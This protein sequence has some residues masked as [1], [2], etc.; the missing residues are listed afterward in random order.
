[1]DY[2]LLKL[3]ADF[4]QSA[5][6]PVVTLLLHLYMGYFPPLVIGAVL[7][8]L[9]VLTSPLARLHLL[10]LFTS[11]PPAKDLKRPWRAKGIMSQYKELKREVMKELNDGKEA[12]GSRKNKKDANR[13]RVG[14]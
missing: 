6:S 12:S 5:I 8:P 1:M 9:T 13:R 10:S 4:K 2:D 14:K 11:A 3:S 7:A